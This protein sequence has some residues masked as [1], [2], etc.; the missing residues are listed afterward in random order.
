MEFRTWKVRCRWLIMTATDAEALDEYPLVV[1]LPCHKDH[2]FDLDCIGPW[3]KMNPTCPMDRKDFLH[4][5]TPPPPLVDDDDEE[6]DDM[7]A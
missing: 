2:I 6:Y 5:K 1:R 3:L 4:K 7:Y